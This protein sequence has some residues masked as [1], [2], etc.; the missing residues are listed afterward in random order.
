MSKIDDIFNKSV[1]RV[2]EAAE[3]ERE[4]LDS[5]EEL[6]RPETIP[7]H[8]KYKLMWKLSDLKVYEERHLPV[9]VIEDYMHYVQQYVYRILEYSSFVSDYS[10]VEFITTNVK[11]K[12]SIT[13]FRITSEPMTEKTEQNDGLNAYF[14]FNAKLTSGN[15]YYQL[16]MNV[17]HAMSAYARQKTSNARYAAYDETKPMRFEFFIGS[18][19]GSEYKWVGIRSL[20]GKHL[21]NMITV[22]KRKDIFDKD[23]MNRELVQF[24]EIYNCFNHILYANDADGKKRS[25]DETVKMTG[26]P[27]A[28]Y[29]EMESTYL[30]PYLH[31]PSE[32]KWCYEYFPDNP[33]N[34]DSPYKGWCLRKNFAEECLEFPREWHCEIM[35]MQCDMRNSYLVTEIY[36]D[37]PYEEPHNHP[38]IEKMVCDMLRDVAG[39][40]PYQ[41]K[42]LCIHYNA[43]PAIAPWHKT[44]IYMG[45]AWNPDPDNLMHEWIMIIVDTEFIEYVLGPRTYPG[46]CRQ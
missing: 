16:V 23:S 33:L 21:D 12:D 13:N 26:L 22:W 32:C 30:G 42:H 25:Y 14:C 27:P 43:N 4:L 44:F 11:L 37:S 38:K 6:R 41:V 24:D 36:K 8:F 45:A 31:V 10:T 40:Q 29:G 5:I 2:D 46:Y 20:S 18:H 34:Q 1:E 17:I 35:T 28:N 39:R 7:D 15:Q 9:Y 19:I 3:I